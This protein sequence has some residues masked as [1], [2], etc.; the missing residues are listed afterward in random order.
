MLAPERYRASEDASRCVPDASVLDDDA[1]LRCRSFHGIRR[2]RSVKADESASCINAA[3]F[4]ILHEVD[5]WRQWTPDFRSVG[6]EPGFADSGRG[7]A[8]GRC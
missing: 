7:V 1:V 5:D 3:T 8:A 2:N 6:Q 4:L